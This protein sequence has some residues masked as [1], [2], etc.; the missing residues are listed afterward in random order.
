MGKRALSKTSWISSASEMVG[1]G[2]G[3]M[4]DVGVG[5]NVG[6]GVSVTGLGVAVTSITLGVGVRDGERGGREKLD[7]AISEKML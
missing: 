5:V 1:V 2:V 6:S 4:V 3:V 7:S